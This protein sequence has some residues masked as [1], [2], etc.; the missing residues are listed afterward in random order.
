VGL[1]SS[2]DLNRWAIHGQQFELEQLSSYIADSY[3]A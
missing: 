1:I 3:P 2:G